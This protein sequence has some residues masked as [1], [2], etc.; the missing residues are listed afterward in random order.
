MAKFRETL[1]GEWAIQHE[2]R[3]AIIAAGVAIVLSLSAVV[4]SYASGQTTENITIADHTRVIG[5][6]REA[7]K[8]IP[9]HERRLK[10]LESQSTKLDLID[11]RTSRIEGKVDA[12]WANPGRGSR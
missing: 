6:L 7:V 11:E 4:S 5:E 8:P 9:D 12:I 2:K 1:F 10:S 3:V